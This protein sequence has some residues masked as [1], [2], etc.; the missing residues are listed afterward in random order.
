MKL[1][2]ILIL[3]LVISLFIPGSVFAA[4]GNKVA[5]P[6]NIENQNYS[7][8]EI[9]EL[10]GKYNLNFLNEEEVK[11]LELDTADIDLFTESVSLEEIELYIIEQQ[12][13]LK[14]GIKE[15]FNVFVEI[16]DQL[17]LD[18]ESNFLTSNYKETKYVNVIKSRVSTPVT[19]MTIR[20]QVPATYQYDYVKY[21]DGPPEITNKKWTSTGKGEILQ[22]SDPGY[23]RFTDVVYNTNTIIDDI[24]IE[25][26]FKI[27]YDFYIGIPLGSG[28][29]YIKMGSNWYESLGFY[30][31]R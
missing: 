18:M 1:K 29:G 11:L 10:L 17:S 15:E 5:K 7:Y 12:N 31:L 9:L 2:K 22:T 16:G 25:N 21:P 6:K 24:T 28:L 4:E 27:N 13:I 30:V 8:S 20:S 23:N 19:D 14:N 3:M 26:H